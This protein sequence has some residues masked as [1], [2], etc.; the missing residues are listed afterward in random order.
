[1]ILVTGANGMVGSYIKEVF[2]GEDLCLTDL[3]EMDVTNYGLVKE[4][5]EKVKP[6]TILH[7][8]AKTDVDKCE[9]EIDDA[10]R[11]NVLGT[12]NIALLCQ[13]KDIPMIYVSTAGVFGGEK[14]EPYTEFD[15]PN[16]V[17][18]YG[19]AKLEGEKIVQSLLN[20]YYIV[21]PGWMM[22]GKEKDK[23]FVAKMIQLFEKTNKV[24]V[25][26]DKIGS[27]TYARDLVCGI[28]ELIKT[29]YYG[30]Y[31]MTNHGVCSRYEV[32]KEIARILKKDIMIEPVSSA[33]FPLPALRARSETMRNF[34]LELLGIIK[35]REWQEALEDYLH[36]WFGDQE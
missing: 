13:K 36:S 30:L 25:V 35:M 16:P 12:Q 27:P 32:A 17:N 20:K 28:K 11:T 21:R 5:V 4:M 24:Q 10:F 9:S 18:V 29:N 14:L 15:R 8:A 31:H 6:D 34:K 22:G 1:M 7:L 33:L 3:P 23:K 2:K 26:I 19:R